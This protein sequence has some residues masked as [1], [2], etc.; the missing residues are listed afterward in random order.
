MCFCR[1]QETTGG[2]EITHAAA[3]GKLG[4]Q[5]EPKYLKELELDY[6]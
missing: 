3:D 4:D 6:S 1:E 5:L 2:R